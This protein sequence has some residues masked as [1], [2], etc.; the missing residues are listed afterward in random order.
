M[1]QKTFKAGKQENDFRKEGGTGKKKKM[2]PFN[3]SKDRI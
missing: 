3:K 2:D 1:G